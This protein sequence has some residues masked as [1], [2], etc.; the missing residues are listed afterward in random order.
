MSLYL[1]KDNV[2]NSVL[3][4]TRAPL[5]ESVMKAGVNE[6]TTFHSS[7]PYVQLVERFTVPH[8][9]TAIF[10]G[11]YYNY[12]FFIKLPDESIELVNSGYLF[13]IIVST[14]NTGGQRVGGVIKRSSFSAQ[15]GSHGWSEPAYV[16]RSSTSSG[17]SGSTIASTIYS[18]L[19]ITRTD[20]VGGVLY[21]GSHN[22]GPDEVY[23]AE[24]VFYN[25]INTNID[26]KNNVNEI[27]L[28][29]S[30]FSIKTSSR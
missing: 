27:I 28:S 13:N 23:T 7:L 12:G 3:H 4:T 24:I 18:Y 20:N 11:Q 5:G 25:I 14:R 10:N 6:S 15:T 8:Y 22:V 9:R 19:D 26:I 16:W 30:E 17:A 1:G 29:P 21:T 2:G